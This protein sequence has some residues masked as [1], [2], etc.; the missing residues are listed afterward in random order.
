M[1]EQINHDA[2]ARASLHLLVRDIERV[3][4]QVDAL[5][6]LTA[7]LGNV[8]RPRRPST[9]AGFVVYGRAPAP[10]VRLAQELRESV[11]TLVAA[12]VEFDRA[13]GFSWDS[14]GSAL[15]VTKQAVHRRYGMRR[16]ASEL[17]AAGGVPAPAGAAVPGVPG[18]GRPDRSEELPA[19]APAPTGLA[20]TGLAATVPAARQGGL[21]RAALDRAA[22]ERAPLDRTGLPLRG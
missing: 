12:A 8:Y 6:T 10:T 4:R 3:R 7:Q 2:R 11:E 18:P 22:H 1:A 15:G 13:L 17:L 9:S 16:P 21:D 19:A 20:P 14:V 5:R